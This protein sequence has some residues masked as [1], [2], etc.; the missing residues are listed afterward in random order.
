MI[1]WLY[2]CSNGKFFAKKK[3]RKTNLIISCEA[4]TIKMQINGRMR[5]REK[6]N[7]NAI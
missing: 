1:Y 3:K 4:I 6:K 7:M 5:E 2:H